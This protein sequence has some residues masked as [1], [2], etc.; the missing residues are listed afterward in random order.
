MNPAFAQ[1]FAQYPKE[2][3]P[4]MHKQLAEWSQSR[5][6]QGLRVVHHVPLFGNTL[7]KI[8]CL[9]EA[10]AEV[11]V[12]NPSSLCKADPE[13]IHCLRTAGI[14]YEENLESLKGESFDLYFDCGA[15]LY[16][17]LGAPKMGAI[18]LTGSGDL[19]Y[20][21]NKLSF[22]VYSIDR[23]LTKQLETVFG[24]AQSSKTALQQL[25]GIDPTT[26]PWIIFGFGK[27]GRG[28]AYFCKQNNVPVVVVDI[29]P[30]QRKLAT[31]LGIKAIDPHH[32]FALKEAVQ[33][34]AIVITATGKA[35][36]M[37]VYPC[38]WFKEKTL[39]NLGI[40]DEFGPNFSSSEVLNGKRAINF[41]LKDPTPMQFIDP[42][43]Y[44]H[45]LVALSV[46]GK[47]LPPE[48]HDITL[49]LDWE[50]IELW[51]TLHQFSL[52]EIKTWFISREDLNAQV[53]AKKT[54]SSLEQTGENPANDVTI[55]SP[56]AS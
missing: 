56:T 11:V 26:Q 32:R 12:T 25:T 45:N 55:N 54:P 34:A 29:D 41:I 9:V 47:P 52:E 8:A 1:Y 5:P 2:T 53:S 7:L 22:P 21:A 27:I 3:A 15:E 51:C 43:F 36:A 23:S 48:V 28:L 40:Y 44:I 35:N 17:A 6:L 46:V 37:S 38:E 13:A 14:R 42:E 49:G 18:E 50:V 16:Q 39:A 19:W 4:F 10:G 24:C 33:Q 30:H 20:R 31:D